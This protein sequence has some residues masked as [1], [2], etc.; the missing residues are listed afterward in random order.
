MNLLT[1][2]WLSVRRRSGFR[3]EVEFARLAFDPADLDP[4]V[5]IDFARPDWSAAVTEWA[6]GMVTLMFA[7]DDTED[8]VV[9]WHQPP[10]IDIWR[11][12]CA[13]FAPAYELYGH[14]ARAFQD[15]DPLADADAKPIAQLLIDQPG[16]NTIKENKDLFVKRDSVHSLS[17]A[18]T[19]AAL[20]TLQTYA[21]SGGVGH[22][23]SMRGGGPLTTLINPLYSM[24]ADQPIGLW[25]YLW[26]NVLEKTDRFRL[27]DQT[28]QPGPEWGRLF[29]WLMPTE[30]KNPIGSDD[31]HPLAC[32]FAMPRRIRLDDADNEGRVTLYRTQNYGNNYVNIRNPLSP[33]RKDPKSLVEIPLHPNPGYGHYKDWLD[34]TSRDGFT[35]ADPVRT[36]TGRVRALRSNADVITSL[37]VF[38]Y[39]MDN[40]KARHWL[41]C[42][43]KLFQTSG[44]VGVLYDQIKLQTDAAREAC[45]CLAYAVKLVRKGQVDANG[46]P[47]LPDKVSADLANDAIDL[48]WRRTEAFFV[49]LVASDAQTPS[50]DQ[51]RSSRQQWY[52]HLGNETRKIFH[53]CVDE[54]A[55][56][57]VNPKLY[58]A[59]ASGLSRSMSASYQGKTSIAKILSV[60]I[61][62]PK[63]PKGKNKP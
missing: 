41:G 45:K 32:F 3:E 49:H 43:A 47:T 39:D 35:G 18:E 2:A 56:F 60:A 46:K 51:R 54:E 13:R 27:P 12:Q 19:A 63:R 26:A 8:W 15:S 5:A 24:A 33:H 14:G 22:R 48:F 21:P 36:W 62:Q 57:A 37:D 16:D 61:N 42:S 17:L 28:I 44:D 6:I 52:D 30:T 38:G 11:E 31:I 1:T 10:L 58:V 29:P 40:M 55:A 59:A 50:D 23:T 9:G 20:I 7:P 53:L 25:H 4:V 34:F